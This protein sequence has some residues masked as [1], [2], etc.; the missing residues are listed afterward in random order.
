MSW[1]P[2]ACVSPAATCI[3]VGPDGTPQ[4][5]DPRFPRRH[6]PSYGWF[7]DVRDLGPWRSPGAPPPLGRVVSHMGEPHP[8]H[9]EQA[10]LRPPDGDPA[11]SASPSRTDLPGR[12][13]PSSGPSVPS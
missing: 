3:V 7:L 10:I 9:P 6:G 2:L 13:R 8:R 11:S 5:S 12:D 4:E 1:L